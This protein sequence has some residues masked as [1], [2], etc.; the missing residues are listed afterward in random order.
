LKLKVGND[1]IPWTRMEMTGKLTT[2]SKKYIGIP[3][4]T[5]ILRHIYLTHKYGE[6]KKEMEKDA[7]ISAHSTNTQNIIY[8]KDPNEMITQLPKGV[9]VQEDK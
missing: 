8:I 7:N 4:G 6:I 9:S 3:I 5:Q 2:Y 1:F